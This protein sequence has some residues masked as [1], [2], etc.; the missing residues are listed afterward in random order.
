[1]LS[2]KG[3]ILTIVLRAL[4]R[5]MRWWRYYSIVRYTIFMHPLILL[6]FPNAPYISGLLIF[7]FNLF[8]RH[9]YICLLYICAHIVVTSYD[10]HNANPCHAS[11][12]LF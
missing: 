7:L 9:D 10:T 2:D 8:L 11:K 5:K 1:M 12:D 4:L 3:E 6:H